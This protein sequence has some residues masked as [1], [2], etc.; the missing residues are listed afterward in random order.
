M[1][2]QL[3]NSFWFAE[4][5]DILNN[6][7]QEEIE[8]LEYLQKFQEGDFADKEHFVQFFLNAA[9]DEIFILGMRLFMAIASHKDFD[10]FEGFLEECEEDELNVFLAYVQESLSLY[11]I[12]Y[13]LALYETWEETY[14]GEDIARCICG[15]LGQK[16]IEYENYDIEQLGNLF[17][18][19]ANEHDLDLYY[20]NGQEFYAGDI[21]K[22]IIKVAMDCKNRNVQFYADQP[23]SILSNSFGLECPV[24]NE[25]EI[26]EDKIKE[27]YN[28]VEKIASIEQTK[29][30]KY[31]YKNHIS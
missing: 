30:E 12:P 14:I 19:F 17:K 2:E 10:L 27:L 8:F 4:V 13:L 11:A 31:F 20:Y 22:T 18:T 15:M 7:G 9:D 21:S 16:Y 24:S 5:K 1:I 6:G 23:S 28:Y 26:D 3:M 25:T 29:G